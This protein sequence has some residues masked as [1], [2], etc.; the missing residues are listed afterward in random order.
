L[1]RSRQGFIARACSS[2]ANWQFTWA[3]PQH[4]DR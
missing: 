3:I 1:Q 4:K 2:A